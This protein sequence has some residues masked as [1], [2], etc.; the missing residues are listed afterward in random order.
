MSVKIRILA[1]SGSLRKASIN[2]KMLNIA[3]EGAES[4]GVIVTPLCLLDYPL[5]LYDQDCEEEK[6]LPEKAKEIKA[7]MRSHQGLLI[8]SPEYNSSYTAA[9][10]N[11][12][13]WASRKESPD[14]PMLEAFNGKVAAI[15]SASPGPLGG[16]KGLANLR[17][18][19]EAINVM[20]IPHQETLPSAYEMIEDTGRVKVER[21]HENI[22]NLGKELAELLIQLQK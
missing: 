11:F 21:K 16:I 7:L 13:D 17:A 20:V 9:L 12:I 18:L 3:I 6:G 2:R 15:M 1:I 5:P 14:E 19:L 10:K 8:A 22:F 4:A